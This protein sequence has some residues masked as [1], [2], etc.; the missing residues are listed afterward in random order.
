M[1]LFM[2]PTE[3]QAVAWIQSFLE[4]VYIRGECGARSTMLWGKE[5]VGTQQ[6]LGKH[7]KR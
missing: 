5:S 7:E 1:E 3:K 6:R 2:C 4:L